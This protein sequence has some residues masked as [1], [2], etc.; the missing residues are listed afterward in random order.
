M[1]F[2]FTLDVCGFSN[3]QNARGNLVAETAKRKSSTFGQH[4]ETFFLNNTKTNHDSKYCSYV[5]KEVT[6]A[7]KKVVPVTIN[8]GITHTSV[9]NLI[10]RFFSQ[11]NIS[12]SRYQY[13]KSSML[14]VWIT[15]TI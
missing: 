9:I 14:V 4:V 10:Y 1:H 6:R 5:T 7:N 11:R 2:F 3:I 12:F 15:C 13:N 8:R